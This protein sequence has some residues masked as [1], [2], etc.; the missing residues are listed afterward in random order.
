MLIRSTQPRAVVID[1]VPD[2][3]KADVY[4]SVRKR[5]EA[6][7]EVL[8]Y[9]CRWF[10][11]NAVDFGVP[12]DRRHG[13]LVAFRDGLL[14]YFELPSA[15]CPSPPTTGEA[16]LDS[17]ASRGWPGADEWALQADQ[18][19]PTLVGGSWERGGADLGPTGSKK[20]WARMGVDG[21]TVA[22]VV[23]GPDF[24]WDPSLGRPGMMALTTNQAAQL[25]GFPADWHVAGRK[26]AR[27]RQV[28]NAT[29]PPLA[30]AV[31]ESIAV[32]LA[33][34]CARPSQ[35]RLDRR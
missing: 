17:M 4:E 29:P 21:G 31:G 3:A 13:F 35:L 26:T 8:G 25:Q 14:D 33:S 30:R 34:A 2:L 1:N 15:S 32:A 6:D 28:A 10:D 7:L 20:A 27:Y 11:L 5:T 22:D 19:A 23:P 18:V 12:Q 16:L 9:R 24:L